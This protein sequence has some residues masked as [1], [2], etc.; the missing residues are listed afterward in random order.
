MNVADT[1]VMEVDE[2]T[3]LSGALELTELSTLVS[4]VAEEAYKGLKAAIEPQSGPVLSDE[5]RFV[6]DA[7]Y[8]SFILTLDRLND[9]RMC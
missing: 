9:Y 1:A 4:S 7:A 8:Q 6:D 5:Q 3:A 2:G